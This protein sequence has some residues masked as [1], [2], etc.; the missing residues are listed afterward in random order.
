MVVKRCLGC[1]AEFIGRTRRKY[2][3]HPCC[4]RSGN[5]PR[6]KT[7]TP[8]ATEHP[9]LSD[10]AWA[11]GIYEGEGSVHG[12]RDGQASVS[13]KHRWILDRLVALFGGTVRLHGPRNIYVWSV[14]GSRARGFLMTIFTF[15]SPWRRGQLTRALGRA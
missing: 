13:Q 14:S 1:G 11:A 15:L 8:A 9:T 7:R 12:R 3:S 2:C 5:L 4:M 6:G 10:L